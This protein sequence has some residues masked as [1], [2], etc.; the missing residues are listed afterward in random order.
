[1]GWIVPG[2]AQ[3]GIARESHSTGHGQTRHPR[4]A[5]AL[6]LPGAAGDSQLPSVSVTLK[7]T[8]FSG[9]WL[10]ALASTTAARYC[11]R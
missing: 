10:D 7:V 1:M 8:V 5:A 4:V 2:R 6:G 3:G 9:W 11:G